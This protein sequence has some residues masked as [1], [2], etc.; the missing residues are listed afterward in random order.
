M[1]DERVH[2]RKEVGGLRLH[3]EAAQ[4]L[5]IALR[6]AGGVVRQKAVRPAARADRA[7]EVRR[8]VKE[9]FVQI[10]RSVQIEQEEPLGAEPCKVGH[11]SGLL[12]AVD[13]DEEEGAD[14]Q[15][16]RIEQIRNDLKRGD[17][18]PQLVRRGDG[19][20]HLR[21]VGDDALEDA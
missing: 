2:A 8:A 9:P 4:L 3:A 10:E 6:P 20:E 18:I 1:R 14:S 21:A 16:E 17:L 13:G 12:F 5:H 11:G 7:Q 15:Q 19:D